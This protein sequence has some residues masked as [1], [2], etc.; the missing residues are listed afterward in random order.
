MNNTREIIRQVSET[1]DI[2]VL[3]HIMWHTAKSLLA[4]QVNK[5]STCSDACNDCKTNQAES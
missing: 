5:Q 4:W 3:S 2:G 1:K